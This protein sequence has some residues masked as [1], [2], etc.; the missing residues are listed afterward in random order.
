[1]CKASVVIPYYKKKLFLKKTVLSV[2]N[3]TFKKFEIIIIYDDENKDD[4]DFVRKIKSLDKRIKLLINN[5]NIGQ[6]FHEILE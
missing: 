5:K 4:L 6:G 2:I 3:Q 1:M